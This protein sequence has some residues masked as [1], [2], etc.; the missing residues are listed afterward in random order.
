VPVLVK[1]KAA[2][3]QE[4]TKRDKKGENGG[5]HEVKNTPKGE[6]TSETKIRGHMHNI[7]QDGTTKKSTRITP[8]G[9]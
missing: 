5:N 8:D 2:P 7:S 9:G 1:A 4:E 3:K 6:L